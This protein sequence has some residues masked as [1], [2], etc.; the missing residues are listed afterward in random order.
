MNARP[1][2]STVRAA[3]QPRRCAGAVFLCL[4]ISVVGADVRRVVSRA[5]YTEVNSRLQLQALAL[6]GPVAYI[7]P[8]VGAMM[9]QGRDKNRTGS[10]RR[11]DRTWDMWKQEAT[12]RTA[13]A[14]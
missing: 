13:K 12:G 4:A 1:S 2:E 5:I 11:Q 14:P 10:G 6:G 8:E 7:A 9:E 3:P